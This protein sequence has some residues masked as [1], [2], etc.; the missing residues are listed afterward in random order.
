MVCEC[1]W[2]QSRG[3]KTTPPQAPHLYAALGTPTESLKCMIPNS[4][5]LKTSRADRPNLQMWGGARGVSNLKVL[6]RDTPEVSETDGAGVGGG[7][8][9]WSRRERE[10]RGEGGEGRGLPAGGWVIVF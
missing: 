1:V 7:G 8:R 2:E 4:R 6:R 3:F 9:S 5:V 10:G